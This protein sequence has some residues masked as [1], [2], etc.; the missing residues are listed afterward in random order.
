MEID[1]K[2]TREELNNKKQKIFDKIKKKQN[3]IGLTDNDMEALKFK[4]PEEKT[5]T[6]YK[7]KLLYLL[8]KVVIA[9][10]GFINENEFNNFATQ[11]RDCRDDLTH[12][13]HS[14]DIEYTYDLPYLFYYSQIF[15]YALL[16]NKIG[17]DQLKINQIMKNSEKFG[18]YYK[19][20]GN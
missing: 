14:N 8:R 12:V 9:L 11:L 2:K 6:S 4:I 1:Y 17:I 7:D 19:E 5:R 15:F 10:N 3:E 18:R 16:T 20:I 13:N